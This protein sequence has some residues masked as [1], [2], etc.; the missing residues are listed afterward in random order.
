MKFRLVA[1]TSSYQGVGWKYHGVVG[2]TCPL[3]IIIIMV[4]DVGLDG[5]GLVSD[6]GLDA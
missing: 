6:F 2:W 5:V 1:H 4:F 3:L